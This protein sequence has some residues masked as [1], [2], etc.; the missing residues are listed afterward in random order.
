M[1]EEKKKS[2][3]ILWI[4]IFL[5]LVIGFGS[6]VRFNVGNM[7]ELYF[8]EPLS[9]IPVVKNILPPPPIEEKYN[10]Y[11]NHEFVAEIESLEAKVLALETNNKNI[12][13]ENKKQ[14][15]EI[16][17][18]KVYEKQQ[19]QFAATKKEFDEAVIDV[20]R[21]DF[22]KFFKEVYPENA[23]RI[24]KEIA[25]KEVYDDQI[26]KYATTY[27]DMESSSA[28]KIL[29]SMMTTDSELVANVLKIIDSEKRADI[30]ANMSVKNASKIAKRMA[31]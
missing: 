8:R 3:G 5:A 10:Y 16:A 27:S 9:G 30:L 19:E 2:G 1:A 17:I 25:T 13:E 15:E 29:E 20:D 4:V 6:V 12:A 22:S 24:Y 11:S 31:P 28:A 26:K 23:E 21:E 14:K 18:L 7:T